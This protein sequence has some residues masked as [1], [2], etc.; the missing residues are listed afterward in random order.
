MFFF[1]F[2]WFF[3]LLLF[4]L[5]PWIYLVFLVFPILVFPILPTSL[6][7]PSLHLVTWLV[8]IR[9][10]W[11]NSGGPRGHV[12]LDAKCKNIF[13]RTIKCRKRFICGCFDYCDSKFCGAKFFYHKKCKK[14]FARRRKCKKSFFRRGGRAQLHLLPPMA[15]PKPISEGLFNHPKKKVLLKFSYSL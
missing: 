8:P 10:F 9:L 3:Y 11:V 7:F 14:S 2:L 6:S 4:R 15:C 13:V 1:M 12:F 5:N